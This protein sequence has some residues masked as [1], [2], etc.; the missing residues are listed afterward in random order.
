LPLTQAGD[1]AK[2]AWLG[3]NN[4]SLVQTLSASDSVEQIGTILQR[5]SVTPFADAALRQALQLRG[6]ETAGSG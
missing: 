3:R 6:V 4:Q 2:R 1:G 5:G